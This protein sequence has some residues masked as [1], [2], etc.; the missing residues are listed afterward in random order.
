M[1]LLKR[2]DWQD[3]VD[4]VDW[5]F[6]FVADDAIFPD[7]LAGSGKV[8]REEW[9]AW[10]AGYR[11][12][13]P[14]Y[15]ETQRDKEAGVYAVKAAL[16]RS[17]VFPKLAEGWKAIAKAH[18]GAVAL[19]EYMGMIG[20][21]RMARF[22]LSPAWRNMATLGALDEMRHT[23]LQLA[24]AHQLL[25][26]DPQFDWAQR[27]YHTND[28][29][30]VAA[31]AVLDAMIAG[32]NVVDLALQLPFT[33]ETGFTN[34]QFVALAADAL[35]A[36]DVN[37]ANMISSIQTD[38]A[39]HA[40]QGGP[41][42]EILL[43]HDPARAQW[44]V[45]KTFWLSA[46]FFA[47]VT[48]PAM[49]YYTPVEHRRQSY[50]DF[51]E[52]WIVGQFMRSLA[53]YGLERPW[54]WDEFLAG[55]DVWQHSLH[56]GTWF[57]RPTLW[58]R[59]PAGVSRAERAWLSARY[60]RWEELYGPL[61]DVIIGNVNADRMEATFPETLPWLCNSCHLP[62]S[63]FS[64]SPYDGRWQVRSFP[65]DHDGRIY[66]FCS[67]PC[68][69]IWW[70]DKDLYGVKTVTERLVTGEIQPPDFPGVLAWM[71]LTPDVMGDDGDGY[72]W[73]AEYR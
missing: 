34:L 33:F 55:L 13:Y 5:T 12:T 37:F 42:L 63:T 73:A 49:D 45:D 46:R 51:M 38:E 8:P 18:F 39:R 31:R 32:P 58:W 17:A 4:D 16:G 41:T 48:G 64:E 2:E 43:E 36:G 23:Q 28:W 6:G 26:H 56:L 69:Q 53:D 11:V 7:W 62:I 20:E 60:P 50:K 68:R 70:E 67:K 25:A 19:V 72:R 9:A 24:V 35:D 54:Y 66:H 14:D 22:G 61:W 59:P 3:L 10:R 65:L 40:Q 30:V 52:E 21:L 47:A 27:A 71:G 1:A 15:V 29:V 57:W 44:V